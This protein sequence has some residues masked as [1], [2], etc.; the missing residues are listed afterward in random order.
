MSNTPLTIVANIIAKED[1]IELV[2]TEL[3]KL[4]APTRAEQGCISY[5]MHQNNENPA[6]FV[7]Y[8]TWQDEAV[9]Q[10]HLDSQHVKD[11]L[12]VSED[13][14]AKFELIKLTKLS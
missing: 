12:A 14:M 11:F 13:A 3:S 10:Q 8:E 4:I 1:K 2:K 5:D 9:M 6:H 7:F